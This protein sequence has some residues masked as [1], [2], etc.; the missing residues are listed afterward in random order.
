MNIRIL[1]Y[2]LIFSAVSMFAQTTVSVSGCWPLESSPVAFGNLVGP[3][4]MVSPSETFFYLYGNISTSLSVQSAGSSNVWELGPAAV[5]DAVSYS[6]VKKKDA[7]GQTIPIVFSSILN[8]TSGGGYFITDA[9]LRNANAGKPVL[10]TNLT[11]PKMEAYGVPDTSSS[12]FIVG[13]TFN[14][15]STV[16]SFSEIRLVSGIANNLKNIEFEYNAPYFDIYAEV[17]HGNLLVANENHVFV[18]S[19]EGRSLQLDNI[20][21]GGRLSDSK[22]RATITYGPS[23]NFKVIGSDADRL[24]V[25]IKNTTSA[26]VEILAIPKKAV[27]ANATITPEIIASFP[28]TSDAIEVSEIVRGTSFFLAINNKSSI[29]VREIALNG[30]IVNEYPAVTSTTNAV[31]AFDKSA[32]GVL[33]LAIF[34]KLGTSS[35]HR[36][37]E[38][39][40]VPPVSI[41]EAYLSNSSAGVQL[42]YVKTKKV[43]DS[44]FVNCGLFE[45][46]RRIK[47]TYGNLLGVDQVFING[48][49]FDLVDS[50]S[51]TFITETDQYTADVRFAN[52]C[53]TSGLVKVKV[54]GQNFTPGVTAAIPTAFCQGQNSVIDMTTSPVWILT[55]GNTNLN[56]PTVLLDSIVVTDLVVRQIS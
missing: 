23:G 3:P 42:P 27:V 20:N 56:Y 38:A 44:L 14:R 47:F 17:V 35:V 54:V 9:N 51:R 29:E 10:S 52:Q 25:A 43:N 46:N 21:Y 50:N 37:V 53:F 49:G 40:P 55:N 11:N 39:L 26:A 4:A 8:T 31:F 5:D 32:K 22:I 36:F 45:Y 24:Y 16:L 41:T 6:I 2:S 1:I 18:F 19:S 7:R 13:R 48:R 28:S 15:V 12:L 30:K 34:G 33:R